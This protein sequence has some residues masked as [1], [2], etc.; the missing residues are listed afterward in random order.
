MVAKLA[1]EKNKPDGLYVVPQ[2]VEE[3]SR[4]I[5]EMPVRKIPGIGTVTE[6]ILDGLDFKT[7]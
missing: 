7:C 5:A 1:S 6:Q 4:F 2:N 3:V